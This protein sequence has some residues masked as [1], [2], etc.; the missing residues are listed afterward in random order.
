MQ[1]GD[2]CENTFLTSTRFFGALS[3]SAKGRLANAMQRVTL[4]T[5]ERFITQGDQGESLYIIHEGTCN[6]TVEKA[7]ITHLIAALGPGEIVGEMAILTG[8]HRSANAEAQTDM[9]LWRLS[10]DVF[11]SV[12]EEYPE[13]RHFLTQTITNRFARSPLTADRTIGKYLIQEI[14]GRG[15]W[16]V[17]YMGKHMNLN[18]PV[19][20]KML[21]HNMA[22]EPSFLDEFQNEARIIAALNHENIVKVYDIEHLYKTVFI[23]MELLDGDSLETILS[24]EGKLSIKKATSVLLQICA[25][26]S[27]AHGQGIIHRDIKPGNI[28]M[29]KNDTVK[30]L[31][32]GLACAP[33]TRGI[34]VVGTPLYLSPEQIRGVPVDERTDIYSLG[35]SAFRMVTGREAFQETDIVSLLQIHLYE[36]VPDPR[37]LVPDIP[38]QLRRFILKSTRRDP[39]ARYQNVEQA[40]LDLNALADTIGLELPIKAPKTL[41]MTGLFLFYRDEHHE[42]LKQLIADFGDELKKIGAVLRESDFKDI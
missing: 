21:K 23:I 2:R 20:I 12:C 37:T 35:V 27:Y 1:D 3:D 9:S 13:I 7:G 33:G 15:G 10:K 36:D 16:S 34:R 11:E 22:M 42:I 24:R 39:A 4:S 28:F 25:G 17:V 38:E 14:I 19:S 31:D 5:G 29:Q 6:I 8:E 18:M 41:N 40:L 26:L 30:L 32:F